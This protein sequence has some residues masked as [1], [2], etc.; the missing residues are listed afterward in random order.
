MV[1][2]EMKKEGDSPYAG[3][4][5]HYQLTLLFTC[6]ELYFQHRSFYML[7]SPCFE[8]FAPYFLFKIHAVLEVREEAMLMNQAAS[9]KCNLICS[10]ALPCHHG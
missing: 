1:I 9:T 7:V 5:T 10:L 8:T 6:N 4:A 3:M 2:Y